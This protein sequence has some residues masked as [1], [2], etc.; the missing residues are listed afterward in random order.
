[1]YQK[2]GSRLLS[3]CVPRYAHIICVLYVINSEKMSGKKEWTRAEVLELISCYEQQQCLWNVH[4]K[5][6]K[7]KLA[8]SDAFKELSVKFLTTVEEITRKIH[9]LRNQFN[10]ELKKINSKKSGQGSDDN[11]ISKWPYFK[12]LLFIKTTLQTR[13]TIGNMVSIIHSTIYT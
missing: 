12:N 1:M 7:N 2:L 4:C 11:Y 9:N 5:E 6:Y 8:K 10:T 13:Q 3:S